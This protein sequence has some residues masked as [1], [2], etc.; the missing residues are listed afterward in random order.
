MPKLT[1]TLIQSAP[2]LINPVNDRELVLRNLHI[3]ELENLGATLNQ[4]D[5]L[6][7]CDNEISTLGNLPLLPRLKGLLLANNRISRIDDDLHQGAPDLAEIILTNNRIAELGDIDPLAK[8]TQLTHLSLLNNPVT[9]HKDY[10]LY[11]VHRLPSVRVLDFEKVLDKERSAAKKR[12]AT[13]DGKVL[14]AQYAA[15]RGGSSGV[16]GAGT[17]S[18]HAGSAHAGSSAKPGPA[19]K[20]GMSSEE[21]ARIKEQLANATSMAEIQ[22]LEELLARGRLPAKPTFT[23]S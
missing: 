4:F 10:R 23:T 15:T 12:F 9:R 11:V 18:S 17:S 2:A 22:R 21:I 7:L 20:V 14:A 16:V 5:V 8:C 3:P 13:K 19:A 1:A 6:N